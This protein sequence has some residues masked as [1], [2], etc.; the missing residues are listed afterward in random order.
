MNNRPAYAYQVN[1]A[2]VH[3]SR[4]SSPDVEA[5]ADLPNQA[6]VHILEH[7]EE[8]VPTPFPAVQQPIDVPILHHSLGDLIGPIPVTSSSAACPPPPP[9]V[10]NNITAPSPSR[11]LLP[12]TS[13][14]GSDEIPPTPL[15]PVV[16]VINPF[17]LP[18]SSSA[19]SF[20]AVEHLIRRLRDDRRMNDESQSRSVAS[21]L[22]QFANMVAPRLPEYEASSTEDFDLGEEWEQSSNPESTSF[23][24]RLVLATGLLGF[25]IIGH[26]IGNI[27]YLSR[28]K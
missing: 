4:S 28:S 5:V 10:N 20:Q 26:H 11:P 24:W 17:H 27:L 22:Y 12:Q 8:R 13:N 6:H 23:L 9:L 16:N 1:G 7:P 25:T 21:G 15:T 19:G 3:S 2:S 14:S 18:A